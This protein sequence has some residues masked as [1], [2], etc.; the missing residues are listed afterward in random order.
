VVSLVDITSRLCCFY[1]WALPNS[2]IIS[3]EGREGQPWS[4][5]HTKCV[6]NAQLSFMP[7]TTRKRGRPSVE[8]SATAVAGDGADTGKVNQPTR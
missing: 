5:P 8:A 7:P 1:L 2:I 4:F 3:T 6:P